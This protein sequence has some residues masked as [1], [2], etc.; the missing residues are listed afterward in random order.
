MN[1]I[2]EIYLKTVNLLKDIS[3]V[4]KTSLCI[5]FLFLLLPDVP[6][7]IRD[8]MLAV[9]KD[10][11]MQYLEYLKE[12]TMPLIR[13]LIEINY[14]LICLMVI[15]WFIQQI[16]FQFR[17]TDII[18]YSFKILFP[19]SLIIS[20][21]ILVGP[22]IYISIINGLSFPQ[23]IYDIGVFY[24]TTASWHNLIIA[25]T[26]FVFASYGFVMLLY[27]ESQKEYIEWKNKLR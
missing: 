6:D 17:I 14:T 9:I 25:C 23:K 11:Y 26:P 10:N 18:N 12:F 20:C 21:A 13:W 19:A 15:L 2:I 7:I 5:I 4:Y 24:N 1:Q 22:I 8:K 16:F 27:D 3:L